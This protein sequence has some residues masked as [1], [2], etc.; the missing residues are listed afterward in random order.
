M[1]SSSPRI[2]IRR[3]SIAPAAC[4]ADK[5]RTFV[6]GVQWH[7]SSSTSGD[8]AESATAARPR[9]S[10]ASAGGSATPR[11]PQVGQA[12]AIDAP[13]LASRRRPSSVN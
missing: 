10:R 13:A 5:R 12:V 6:F 1:R 4:I 11:P 8:G 9:R 7:W 2:R 3:P